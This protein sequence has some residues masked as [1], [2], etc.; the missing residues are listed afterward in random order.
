M[1]RNLNNY[2]NFYS[3][4]LLVSDH[5]KKKRLTTFANVKW[6]INNKSFLQSN[7]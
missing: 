7:D 6:F 2:L 3:K 1:V 4:F 5:I